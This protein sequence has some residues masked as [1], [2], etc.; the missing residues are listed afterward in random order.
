MAWQRC[1][2]IDDV[3]TGTMSEASSAPGEDIVMAE[4]QF[5]TGASIKVAAVAALGGFLFG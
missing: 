3:R 1:G 2:F 4:E 5:R